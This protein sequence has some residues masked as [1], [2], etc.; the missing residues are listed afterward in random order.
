MAILAQVWGYVCVVFELF[1]ISYVCYGWYYTKDTG[2]KSLIYGNGN[3]AI[4]QG[5]Q[6]WEKCESGNIANGWEYR[7]SVNA[8]QQG[9]VYMSCEHRNKLEG[10]KCENYTINNGQGW[11]LSISMYRM[12]NG[13]SK[14]F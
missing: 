4:S 10:T 5:T 6:K 13:I 12:H 9:N 2:S 11:G 8:A 14:I 3:I 7:K 1:H